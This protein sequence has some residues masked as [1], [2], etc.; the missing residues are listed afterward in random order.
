MSLSTPTFLDHGIQPRHRLINALLVVETRSAAAICRLAGVQ[1]AN[2]SRARQAGS[3]GHLSLELQENLL[4]AMGW[5]HGTPD[6]DVEHKWAVHDSS[7]AQAAEWL[8]S[9]PLGGKAKLCQLKFR[10][11]N[12]SVDYGPI[13]I[14]QLIPAGAVCAIG[15]RTGIDHVSADAFL[16]TAHVEKYPRDITVSKSV[17][18]LMRR[19]KLHEFGIWAA[20]HGRTMT[21]TSWAR[22][23][24]LVDKFGLLGVE[25]TATLKQLEQVL[26]ETARTDPSGFAQRLTEIEE[27]TLSS[28]TVH[29]KAMTPAQRSRLIEQ[30]LSMHAQ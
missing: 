24:Q 2:L 20:V 5:A 30:L 25:P 17:M 28:G 15:F 4:T 19:N 21:L 27:L 29:P 7:S 23:H 12:G 10:D 16:A 8:L 1:P 3:E 26:A 14:G 9:T 6:K 22:V 11:A 18:E 13:C